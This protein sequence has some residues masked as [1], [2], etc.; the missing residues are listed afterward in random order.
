MAPSLESLEVKIDTI[1]RK[2][3]ELTA[4]Q[5]KVVELEDDVRVLNNKVSDLNSTV[6]K[7]NN[8]MTLLKEKDNDRDQQSRGNAVRLFGLAAGE[9]E[10]ATNPARALIKRVYDCIIKPVLTAAKANKQLDSV[11]SL[12]NTIADAY[13]I[14]SAGKAKQAIVGQPPQAP[15][16]IIVKFISPAIRLAFLRNKR[17][18]LPAPSAAKIQA[19][20]KRYSVVEDL[21]STTY[22]KMRELADSLEVDKVWSIDGRLRYTVP[23][24]KT[25][26]KV[27]SVFASVS[28]IIG[29]D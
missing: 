24:D 25:I 2:M 17:A 5:I 23:G 7:L 6:A 14:R 18:S 20:V 4:L 27:K 15:P 22:K 21:T 28:E 16:P 11:L 8:E 19:G 3:E 12:A 1:L 9:E 13:R 26:Y 10:D 29:S